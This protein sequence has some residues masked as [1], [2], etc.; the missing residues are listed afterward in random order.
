MAVSYKDIN[1]LTQKSSVAGT[2]KLPVSDTEFITPAQITGGF[3]PKT[4]GV[5]SGK[6][7]V[8][9]PSGG[10]PLDLGSEIE[11]NT[12]I[13]FKSLYNGAKRGLA[14]IGHS[15]TMG[16]YMY[17]YLS[18]GPKYLALKNDG[19]LAL[20]GN[21]VYHS[22][23]SNFE[24]KNNKVTS[25]SASSTDDQYPSAKCV[26]DL[27]ASIGPGQETDPTVPAW[28]KASTKPTYTASE[29]GA[30]PDTTVVPNITVSSSEPTSSQ[31]SDGDIWIVI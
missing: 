25:L 21:T 4:G 19:T 20:G 11:D 26:Y 13:Y 8:T 1:Q 30:L 28:A 16:V 24:S 29:V 6:L 5:I 23:N 15:N 9:T 18:T 2:E 22:G 31:G 3:L 17:N 14:E 12:F 7:D 10:C 27:L